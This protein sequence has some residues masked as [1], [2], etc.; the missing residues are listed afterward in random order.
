MKKFDVFK[1]P[2]LCPAG[3]APISRAP[4]FF[5]SWKD[6]GYGDGAILLQVGKIAEA[7]ATLPLAGKMAATDNGA[8]LPQAGEIAEVGATLLRVGE[9]AEA[10]AILAESD[11]I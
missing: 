2:A 5:A 4:M 9:T 7:G 1:A 8:T 6:E 3:E 10:G 11:T